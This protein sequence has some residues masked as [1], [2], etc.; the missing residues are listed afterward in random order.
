GIWRPTT[1]ASGVNILGNAEHAISD[2][3]AETALLGTNLNITISPDLLLKT[4]ASIDYRN[5]SSHA[6]SHS[7]YSTGVISEGSG[8]ASKSADR[9]LSYTVNS[10]IDYSLSF[11][12]THSI[13]LLA[14]PEVY[15]NQ[16]SSLSGSRTGF[17]ILGKTE[18]SA[19]SISGV[20]NGTSNDYR[21]AS[22]LS[23]LDYDLFDR[24]HFS[25]SYRRDGS[26][27]FSKE[28][29]GGEFWSGGASWK[30]IR[31]NFRG[32]TR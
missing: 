24:Y 23:K 32:N 27:R 8:N 7:Y 6:Y 4:S 31:E 15:V 3:K 9:Y 13:N 19:G 12:E 1:A 18:P 10:F 21:L 16:F 30:L 20:F 5:G 25:V 22:L 17:Q 28:T 29:R 26:S 11:D 14:G 2:S